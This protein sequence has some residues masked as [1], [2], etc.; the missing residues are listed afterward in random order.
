MN[1]E[2]IEIEETLKKVDSEL[3]GYQKKIND[4]K[5]AIETLEDENIALPES[6]YG[7]LAYYQSEFDKESKVYQQ[8][9]GLRNRM[10]INCKHDYVLSN[11]EKYQ[12]CKHCGDKRYITSKI[13]L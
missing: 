7:T 5:Q 1:K 2:F 8:L 11:D 10:K 9:V 13:N 4:I 6:A 12:E 3:N